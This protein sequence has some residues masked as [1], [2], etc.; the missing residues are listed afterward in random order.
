MRLLS[1]P[2][3]GPTPSTGVVGLTIEACLEGGGASMAYHIFYELAH[4][5]EMALLC[6]DC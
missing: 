6:T 1:L 5:Y 3:L 4:I 2:I